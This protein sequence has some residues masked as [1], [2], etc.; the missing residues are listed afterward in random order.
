MRSVPHRVVCLLGLDDAVFP[1]KAPRD[2]DDLLLDDPRIGERDPR[3]EDRQLLLDALMAA[4][5]RLIVTFTGNDE[6]TNAP[7]PPAVPVGELLD[8][9]DRT[10]RTADGRPVR[11]Q[12]VVRHPL[13]PFDWRNFTAGRLA[14]A[15]A[16]SFDRVTL[17]GARAL[18][19]G[20]AGP[21]PFLAEPLG[22]RRSPVVALDDLVRFVQ[23]PVRA[24]LRGR[25]GL[26]VGDFST[27]VD[28]ALPVDLDGLEQWD[29][30]QRLLDARLD[31]CD[32]RAAYRAE[33]AR[34]H[35]PPGLLGK[36]VIEKLQPTVEGLVEATEAEAGSRPGETVDVRVALDDGR[37]L[38]GT[39]AGVH[40]DAVIATTY[41]RLAPKHR[42]AAWVRVVAV[43]ASAPEAAYRGV[44][45]GRAKSGDGITVASIPPLMA[46]LDSRRA[47][48][49]RQLA[50]LVD[51]YDRALCE[52]LPIACKATAAYARALRDGGDAD[53]AAREEWQGTYNWSGEAD[54]PEHVLAFG[55]DFSFDDL[56]RDDPRDD[57]RGAGWEPAARTRFGR[58][59]AR[60]WTDLLDVEEVQER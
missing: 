35:L 20:R 40:G 10:V 26:S 15:D 25:L 30:G 42:L 50:A 55:R 57:E 27:D 58:Y 47:F 28:D 41:S 5:E 19:T 34:G 48:A 7:R 59:A 44:T 2:G 24:F 51:L 60:L 56:C 18:T 14:G 53:A 16:W 22:P 37:R 12:V 38:T 1:R 17:A 8:V 43:T 21:P 11:D 32:F 39:V 52:P 9:A 13:Q 3:A 45:I 31:G 36:P 49:R 54:E 33:I 6:R 4:E 46:D 29:I 23:H